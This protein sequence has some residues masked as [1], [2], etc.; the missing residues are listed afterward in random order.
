MD[1]YSTEN[2]LHK[3]QSKISTH[4]PLIGNIELKIEGLNSFYLSRV[5]EKNNASLDATETGCVI[6]MSLDTFK[7]CIEKKASPMSAFMEGD[8]KID[9]DMS[10]AMSLSGILQ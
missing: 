8:L 10:L 3:L 2:I 7:A 9:G 1:Q 4:P 5:D 6:T